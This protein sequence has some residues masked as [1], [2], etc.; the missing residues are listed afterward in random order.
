MICAINIY[1]GL[2]I[3][4]QY[5]RGKNVCYIDN[6]RAINNPYLILSVVISY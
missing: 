3:R 4:Y 5:N 2:I 1:N 6:I